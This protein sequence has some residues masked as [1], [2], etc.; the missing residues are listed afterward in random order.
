MKVQRDSAVVR[1]LAWHDKDLNFISG[2]TFGHPN[3][4]KSD[5]SVHS[6]REVS[7]KHF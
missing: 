5:P 4:T 3:T 6:Q 2:N 7:T 1:A